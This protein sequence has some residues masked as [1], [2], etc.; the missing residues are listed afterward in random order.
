[1]CLNGLDAGQCHS[2]RTTRILAGR[3]WLARLL[4]RGDEL[5][6]ELTTVGQDV[7]QLAKKAVE[8]AIARTYHP[9]DRRETI[10]FPEL[11]VRSTS[12]T[13]RVA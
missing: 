10:V 8:K 11:V 5:D 13:H 3:V 1:V 4:Y 12:R 6:V 2:E 9:A 7:Q